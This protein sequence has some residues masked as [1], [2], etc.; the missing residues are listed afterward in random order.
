M[1]VLSHFPGILLNRGVNGIICWIKK[2]TGM[3]ISI[4]QKSLAFRIPR[5]LPRFIKSSPIQIAM[6]AVVTRLWRFFS[7]KLKKS[8]SGP[9]NSPRKRTAE[10]DIKNEAEGRIRGPPYPGGKKQI[11]T[12]AAKQIDM[13]RDFAMFLPK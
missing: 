12:I 6:A 7:L 2:A 10:K 9:L 11:I 1:K 5:G 13:S 4:P 3:A 8:S